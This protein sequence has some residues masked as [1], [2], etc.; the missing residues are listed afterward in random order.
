[1]IPFAAADKHQRLAIA[2]RHHMETSAINKRASYAES[3]SL[4]VAARRL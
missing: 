2:A 4:S 1:M 3:I